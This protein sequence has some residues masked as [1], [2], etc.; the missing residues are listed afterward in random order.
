MSNPKRIEDLN[1]ATELQDNDLLM[2]SVNN[3]NGIYTSKKMTL[4]A[5]ADYVNSRSGD[6]G[7]GG[8]EIYDLSEPNPSNDYFYN[9]VAVSSSQNTFDHTFSQDCEIVLKTIATSSILN[10]YLDAFVKIDDI[11]IHIGL[12]TNGEWGGYEVQS[13]CSWKMTTLF[14]KAG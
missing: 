14:V 8:Y 10:E 11:P 12:L 9:E 6:S 3:G 13:G 7:F 2:T 1:Q 4:S 5:L